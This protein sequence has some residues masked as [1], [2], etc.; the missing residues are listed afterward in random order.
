MVETAAAEPDE[1]AQ[2]FATGPLAGEVLGG[3]G[4]R[5]ERVGGG[6]P[7]VDVDAVSDPEVVRSTLTEQLAEAGRRLERGALLLVDYGFPAHEFY[8][9]Q[10][11]T[12]TLMCHYRHRAHGDP[13]LWPGLQDIT[14]HV[15]FT[16]LALAA[17]GAGLD[18]LGYASQAAAL[19]NLGLLERFESEA[20]DDALARA[21]RAQSVH[22]LTGDAEMGE[23]FKFVA[24]G[25]GLPDDAIAFARADRRHRL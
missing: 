7:A 19:L 16:A 17:Q 1:L 12:G 20:G 4:G 23:L 8:H 10:R 22:V 3:E 11:G 21:R 13:F 25:R 14:V 15:D 9:P 18:V 5:E 6:V 24:L 2:R